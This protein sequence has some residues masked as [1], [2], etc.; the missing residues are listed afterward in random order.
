LKIVHISASYKGGAGRAAYRIHEALLKQGFSSSFVSLDHEKNDAEN[1]E[2]SFYQKQ[3]NRLRSWIGKYVKVHFTVKES[4]QYQFKK[5]FPRLDCEIATLPYSEYNILE[6][7]AVKEADIIHLHWVA[8]VLDYPSFF[9]KNNKPVV[10]TLHDMNPFQGI[11]HYKADEV[12]NKKDSS[13]LDKKVLQVKRKAIA[14]KKADL[15][16]VSPSNWLLNAAMNSAIFSNI[17]GC[18][19]PYPLNMKV[20]DL[21]S[22]NGLKDRLKIPEVNT[23]FL[24]VAQEIKNYRKGFDLLIAALKKMEHQQLTI[25]VIGNTGEFDIPEL[26][27]RILGIV[28]DDNLLREYISLADAFIIPSRED[29][30]PNVMLEALACGIPVLSFNVGGMAE[31]VK[32]GYTGLKANELTSEGL[33]EI[34][35][36]FISSKNNFDRKAIRDFAQRHFSEELVAEKYKEVYTGILL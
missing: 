2:P 9:Q 20:F 18:C 32:N 26:D 36:L 23:L 31:V 14:N 35:L 33:V 7:P 3:I 6:D 24:F 4:I 30:F 8:G 1:I 16:I 17:G 22:D 34:M 19:I 11:F 13:L 28:N 15:F 12:R 5:I 29:N 10:W 27:I 21:N 25:L